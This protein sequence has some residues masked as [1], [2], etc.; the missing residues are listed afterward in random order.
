MSATEADEKP[1]WYERSPERRD[2]ELGEFE[3][4]GLP[5][6][7][8]I[9]EYGR[10]CVDTEL[11]FRGKP[12]PIVVRYPNDYPDF[13]PKLFGPHGLFDRHQNG[14]G[15]L[16]VLEDPENDWWP[17]WSA[18]ELVDVNLRALFA[19]SER[20]PEAV[21]A[22]EADMVESLSAEISFDAGEAVLVP[23]P[24]WAPDLDRLH[25]E[26]T[27]LELA[28]GSVQLLIAVDA[29]GTADAKLIE[30]LGSRRSRR[31]GGIWVALPEAPG[32]WPSR[33]EIFAAALAAYSDLY[34]RARGEA[35]RNF[36]ERQAHSWIAITFIEEGPR[37]GETRRAWV[38]REIEIQLKRPPETLR[39]VR[40]HPLTSEARQ[41]RTPELVGL[42]DA[43]VA[44]VGAGSLGA[45]VVLE[46]A[47]AGVGR[48]DVFDTDYFEA[49]SNVRHVLSTYDAGMKKAV[50]VAWSAGIL[51]PFVVA[52]ARDRLVRAGNA[53]ELLSEADVVVDTTGSQ[54]AGRM[55]SRA[56]RELGKVLVI[57]GVS[58]GAYGGDVVILKPDG[59]CFMC[60]VLAQIAEDIPSPRSG[61]RSAV[62]PVGCGHPAFSGAGFDATALAAIA[63]RA[64]IGVGGWCDY[65]APEYDWVVV[66]FRGDN[67]WLQGTLERRP[68]CPLC[69]PA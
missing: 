64:V 52:T 35:A 3:A 31:R 61:P 54:S 44:I 8:R 5:A 4:L 20:G 10:L 13:P 27:L 34:Q 48:I 66:N 29:L 58:N 56:C 11:A 45:P 49:S 32:P 50:A 57:A 28:G 18:A 7:E 21:A 30:R 36:R 16:C 68:E 9:D 63:A 25:G 38:F 55:L 62:T 53:A 60:F 19:D 6:S 65:P 22:R 15:N 1:E 24:F 17:G 39:V 47:K 12:I 26:F 46:L 59:P 51:N 40:A 43:R 42:T 41:L 33:E 67:P 2:W 37:R 69:G 14:S 23:D